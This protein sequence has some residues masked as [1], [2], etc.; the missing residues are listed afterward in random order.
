MVKRGD[1]AMLNGQHLQYFTDLLG[2]QRVITNADECQ[3]Y[4]IDWIKNVRGTK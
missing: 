3:P 2:P 1:F 4:N